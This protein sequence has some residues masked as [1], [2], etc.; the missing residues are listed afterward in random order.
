MKDISTIEPTFFGKRLSTAA[1]AL[2]GNCVGG[3]CH[4]CTNGLYPDGR[5][6]LICFGNAKCTVCDG[7]GI[8]NAMCKHQDY[9]EFA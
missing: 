9:H 5:Q 7:K 3:R 8:Y 4:A 2:C 6:C 1:G